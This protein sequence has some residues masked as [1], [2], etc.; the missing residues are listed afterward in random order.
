M[1]ILTFRGNDPCHHGHSPRGAR[2][3]TML[4]DGLN[5]SMLANIGNTS[6]SRKDQEAPV[7]LVRE[8][9]IFEI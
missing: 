8:G 5:H 3:S 7:Q 9:E 1:T 4:D 6:H 2:D